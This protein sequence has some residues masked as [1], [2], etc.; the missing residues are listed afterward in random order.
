MRAWVA[1]REAAQMET[2]AARR[3]M[4]ELQAAESVLEEAAVASEP[5]KSS[6][7]G[8]IDEVC[9]APPVA[10]SVQPSGGGSSTG[11]GGRFVVVVVLVVV[12][13]RCGAAAAA[14]AAGR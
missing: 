2:E 12:G 1:E 6:Y 10:A 7:L 8:A 9:E 11:G 5:S 13:E 4:E 14:A 3:R